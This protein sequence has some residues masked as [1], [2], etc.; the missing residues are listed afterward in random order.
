MFKHLFALFRGRVHDAGESLADRNALAILRQQIRDAAQAVDA[1]R[2]AVAIAIAQNRQEADQHNRLAARIADLE[3]RA[4]AALGQGKEDLAREAA[5]T[6]AILEAECTA[7]VE[8]QTAFN[9]EIL[10][11]T[12]EL[13]QSEARLRDLQRGQRVASAV[14]STQRLRDGAGSSGLSA[15]RDAEETLLRLRMRQ[16]KID[17][18]AAAMDQMSA[19]SDPAAMAERLAEAGCGEP[20]QTTADDVLA[21]LTQA[22]GKAA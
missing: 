5:S 21:R 8:A 19:A 14:E 9:S 18:T 13:R 12:M 17:A 15:L 7:C 10:R 4:I 6:I 11:L 2:K 1:A 22:A 3:T 16:K 20:L